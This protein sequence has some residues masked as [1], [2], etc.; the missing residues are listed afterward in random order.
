[1]FDQ[2]LFARIGWGDVYKGE[3]LKGNFREPNES[4][5]WFERFNFMPSVEG[6]C[7]GYMPPMAGPP[8]PK[9]RDGWLVIFAA[10][11]NGDKG[12]ALLPVGWYEEA[13]FEHSYANRPERHYADYEYIVS[14]ESKNAY[15]IP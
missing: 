8:H 5:S 9:Y 7:Y 10:T 14:T 3:E 11:K 4:N 13:T 1:M 6:R 12:G 15:R 2:I